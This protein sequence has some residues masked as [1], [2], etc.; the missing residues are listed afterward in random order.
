MN[1]SRRTEGFVILF[2]VVVLAASARATVS[3]ERMEMQARVAVQNS[4]HHDSVEAIDWVQE[5]NEFRL[6]LKYDAIPRGRTFL[7]LTRAKLN[8]LY[9]ARYDGV[10]D[11]RDDYGEHGYRRDDMRFPEGKIPRELFFDLEL[12]GVLRPLSARIGRQQVVWGEADVFRSIDVVNPL[13]LDQNGLL[14]DD[15]ADYREPLW[16]AKFFWDIGDL[17]PLGGTGLEFLYS[18]N[19]RPITNRILVGE[20]FRIGVDQNNPVDG[21]RRRN[22]L[23]FQQVRHPWELSRIGP[24]KTEAQDFAELGPVLGNSDFVY[25]IRDDVPTATFSA[26]ATVAGARLLA[27]AFNVDFT[28]NYIFKRTELPGTALHGRDLFDPN[29][30]TDGSFNA[31]ADLLAQAATFAG[32]GQSD[33]L[34]RRCVHEKEPLFVLASIHGSG[35]PQTGCITVPFWYPWTHVLGVTANYNDYDYTGAVFRMEQSYSTKEP[36]N[37]YPPLAGGRAGEFPTARDFQTN[38]RRRTEVWRGMV[39]FDYL[40]SIG[41]DAARSW[42]QPLRSLLGSDQWLL[43]GQFFNEYYSH[44]RGQ[45][46]LLDSITD[47]MH[48]WNPMITFLATGFFVQQRLRPTIAFG[49]DLN[50]QFPVLWAQAEYNIGQRWTVRLGEVLYMGSKH[51]EQFLYLN[52]YADRDTLFL[53][54]TYF[55]V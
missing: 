18:P 38:G 16:I 24:Y 50:D 17:G 46:G 39:G 52:K 43:S 8:L 3:T 48:H 44:V 5:R 45:I 7:G 12:G 35:N 40:R 28:L 6:D 23:P 21:F 47:R 20:A 19:G 33:E 9:R 10:F 37:G 51:A 53:R 15:F 41:I 30:A 29:V 22:G 32:L 31:R 49:Y 42:P 2:L 25:L 36:R 34:I 54:V 26:D 55:L 27:R 14:G 1:G 13:R 11:I 4:F